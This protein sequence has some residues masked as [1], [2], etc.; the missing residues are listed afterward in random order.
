[1]KVRKVA[2]LIMVVLVAALLITA[3][4][5]NGTST[6]DDGGAPT[7]DTRTALEQTHN[8]PAGWEATADCAQCHQDGRTADNY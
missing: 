3:C 4:T 1:M 7:D 5:T 8:R 2:L 6:A